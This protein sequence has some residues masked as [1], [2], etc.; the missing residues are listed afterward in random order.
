MKKFLGV[1]LVA[2]LAVTPMMAQANVATVTADTTPGVASTNYVKGAYNAMAAAVDSELGGKANVDLDNL[3]KTGKSNVSA[4]GTYDA[5]T[6]YD[7]GTVGAAIK[8]KQDVIDA[9]HKLAA[10]VNNA[11]NFTGDTDS[12]LIKGKTVV[13]AI[14]NTAAAVDKINNAGYIT[15]DVNDLTNY[16]TTANMNTALDAKQNLLTNAANA[17]TA[18][19]INDTTHKISVSGVKDAQIASNAA[20]AQSKIKDLTTDLAAK[21]NNADNFTGDTDSALI[22]GKTVVNA[23][24]D[25]ATAVDGKVTNA[26]QFTDSADSA[27]IKTKT[28]VNAIKDTAA[29]VDNINNA[30]YITKDVNNLTYYTTTTKMNDALSGK[31]DT[32]TAGDGIT[33]SNN[34]VS[35]KATSSGSGLSVTASGVKV[36]ADAANINSNA[37]ITAKIKDLNVTTAKIANAAVTEAK[38]GADAVTTVKIKDGAVTAAKLG[39]KI[40]LYSGWNSGGTPTSTTT[41]ALVDP[42]SAS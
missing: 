11:D 25:T 33:I 34:T 9:N 5:S 24:K 20:I 21:V 3:S 18:I 23:I 15:K 35:V 22:K 16:T 40:Q 36:A 14:Q 41:V 19:S 31:Q 8:S 30:G 32:L 42:V 7:A 39:A 4:K 1:S 28:V 6:N 26:G 12:S 38:L 10:K 37:V 13:A 29:A 2:V 27:L 17:G